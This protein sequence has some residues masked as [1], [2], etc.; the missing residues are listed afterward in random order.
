MTAFI[1]D[2]KDAY[3]VEPICSVLPIAPSTYY[4]HKARRADPSRLSRRAK[5]DA[6]LVDRDVIV[7]Q[8]S[9]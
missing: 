4:A 1:D 5:R 3:G 9:E 8:K 6:A 2:H 7:Y